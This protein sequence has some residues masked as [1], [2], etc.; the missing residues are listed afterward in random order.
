MRLN[1]VTGFQ[2]IWD[3]I[4]VAGEVKGQIAIVAEKL[5]IG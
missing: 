1:R 5:L 4:K 2:C 3:N